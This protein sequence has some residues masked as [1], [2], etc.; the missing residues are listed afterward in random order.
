M[1]LRNKIA[2]LYRK[3][4]PVPDVDLSVTENSEVT[5]SNADSCTTSSECQEADG[6]AI[7]QTIVNQ[8]GDHPIHINHVNNLKL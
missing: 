6:S 8:Y 7:H 4:W 3:L 2:E 1:E 5:K